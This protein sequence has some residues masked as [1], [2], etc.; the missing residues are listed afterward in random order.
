MAPEFSLP[1]EDMAV[2][3]IIHHNCR[4]SCSLPLFHSFILETCIA[5]VKETTTQKLSAQSRTKRKDFR[6]M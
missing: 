5:P 6:E 1:S 4:H 3:P 2:M